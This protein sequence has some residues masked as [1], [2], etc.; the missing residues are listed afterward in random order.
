[1]MRTFFILIFTATVMLTGCMNNNDLGSKQDTDLKPVRLST[2][3]NEQVVIEKNPSKDYIQSNEEGVGQHGTEREI[4][5]SRESRQI[6]QQLAK[7]KEISQSRV[8]VTPNRVLVFASLNEYPNDITKQIEKDV[9]PF[10]RDKQIVVFTDEAQWERMQHLDSSL[11]Q[12]EIGED[13][14]QF[15]E[16][17]FNIDIKD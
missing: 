1:M 7:R 4:F 5:N 14:E 9:E 2:Q 11:R 13:I 12:R 6:S 16:R 10:V 17:Y 8:A 3:D 15:L